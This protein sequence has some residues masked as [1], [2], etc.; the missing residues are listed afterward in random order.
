MHY[1][2]NPEHPLTIAWPYFPPDEQAWLHDE[3]HAILNGRLSMGPRVARFEGD[4]AA[5]CGAAY[6]VALPNCTSAL[7][8]ALQALGVAPGDDSNESNDGPPTPFGS[9]PSETL[10]TSVAPYGCSKPAQASHRHLLIPQH[11]N[12]RRSRADSGRNSGASR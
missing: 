9:P 6:G 11:R 10:T 4:F 3:L 12:A 5:Y 8:V 1:E 7:E 2:P